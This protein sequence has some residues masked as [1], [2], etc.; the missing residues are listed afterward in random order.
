M[1]DRGMLAAMS[2]AWGID[3]D[4]DA[5]EIL[6]SVGRRLGKLSPG[7]GVDLESS[8]HVFIDAVSSGRLGRFSLESPESSSPE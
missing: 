6:E 1:R 7:G 2:S 5:G 8:G 3:S 4:G